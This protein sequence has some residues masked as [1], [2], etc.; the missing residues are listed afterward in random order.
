MF[1]AGSAILCLSC[2]TLTWHDYLSISV[3][4][5][6]SDAKDFGVNTDGSGVA[7]DLYKEGR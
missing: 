2:G 5:E 1:E 7:P 4:G 3:G 6:T